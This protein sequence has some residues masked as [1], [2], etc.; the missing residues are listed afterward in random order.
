MLGQRRLGHAGKAYISICG[1]NPQPEAIGAS[2]TYTRRYESCL[3]AMLNDSI[4][5]YVKAKVLRIRSFMLFGRILRRTSKLLL[6]QTQRQANTC[7]VSEKL[8]SHIGHCYAQALCNSTMQGVALA[9]V[10]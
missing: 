10:A 3:G 5:P 9:L 7:Q 6:L 4:P 1:G 8:C 2:Q